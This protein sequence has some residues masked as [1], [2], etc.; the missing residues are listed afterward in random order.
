VR[1]YDPNTMT[2]ESSGPMAVVCA[3]CDEPFIDRYDLWR[4]TMAELDT[5]CQRHWREVHEH[6]NT[7]PM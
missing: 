6:P 1:E 4:M 5:A 3:L 7:T 2:V